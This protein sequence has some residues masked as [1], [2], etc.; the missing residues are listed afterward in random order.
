MVNGNKA[1]FFPSFSSIRIFQ[2]SILSLTRAF[3]GAMYTTWTNN[4]KSIQ[5]CVLYHLRNKLNNFSDLLAQQVSDSTGGSSHLSGRILVEDPEHGHLCCYGFSRASRCS[6]K[7]IGVGVIEGVK[8]LSL[9]GVEVSELVE[10][11]ILRVAKR[12]HRQW[13]QVQKL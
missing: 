10:T 3:R 13:L 4:N 5:R 6:Q 1:Y 7:D 11:L 8:D 2:S 9:D 12:R